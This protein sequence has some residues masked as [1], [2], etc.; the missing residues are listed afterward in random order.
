MMMPMI[1]LDARPDLAAFLRRRN[2]LAADGDSGSATEDRPDRGQSRPMP[3]LIGLGALAGGG[4]LTAFG[5]FFLKTGAIVFGSGLAIVPFL[6]DGVVNQPHWL[7]DGQSA[8]RWA[9]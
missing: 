4:T 8:H 9:V 2:A 3:M 7:T 5:L 1:A 6:C